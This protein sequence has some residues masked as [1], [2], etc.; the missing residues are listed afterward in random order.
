M[1]GFK[2]L[3]E[4]L[5]ALTTQRKASKIGARMHQRLSKT[6]TDSLYQGF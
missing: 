2:G 5:R 4:N 6:R 1:L 3:I